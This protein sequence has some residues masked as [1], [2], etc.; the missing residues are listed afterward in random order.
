LNT[1]DA[2]IGN[3]ISN[4]TIQALPMEGR[5]VPDLLSL[6]PGVLYL[7]RQT[8][9]QQ[10]QDSRSGVVAGAR[11]DQSNITLDGVDNN[12]QTKGYAFQGV[13][14]STLDSVEEFRVTTTNSNA[15]A[16][17]S[18]GAQVVMVTKS[19]TNQFHGSL[20][21]YN[22]DTIFAANDWFNKQ[23][24]LSSG[25]PN[26]PGKLIRNTYGGTFGGP[27]KK[28]KLFFFFNYEGQR[29]AENA[30]QVWTV[31]TAAFRAGNISYPSNGQTISLTPA[32]IQQM[33]PNCKS[34]GTCAV[35]G[36]NPAVLAI[37]NQMP[38]PNGNVAGDGY[39]T[40]SF[41]WSA[42][43]PTHL[44]TT[45]AK[46]D[47]NLTNNNRLFIRGNLQDDRTAGPPVFPGTPPRYTLSTNNKGLAAGDSWTITPNLF[48]S[49]RYGY[50][51]QG[52]GNVGAGGNRS[53]VSITAISN[54]VA[55]DR[56]TLLN[57]P[58]HNLTDDVTWIKGRH[59]FQFGAN[60]RLLHNNSISDSTS[61][62]H[63]S[64]TVGL[65]KYVKVANESAALGSPYSLDP[66]GFGFPAVDGGFNFSYDTDVLSLTGI[67]TLATLQ[68]NYQVSKDGTTGTQLPV[69]TMIP[70]DFKANEFEWYVQDAWRV[71]PNLT[72][73]FGVR[74]S[75]LQTPYEVNGQQLQPDISMDQWFKSRQAGM[76]QGESIQ[77]FF[78]FSPSGQ[79]RGL[80]PYWPMNPLNFAPR[81]SVAYSPNIWHKIFGGPGKSSIRA[82]FG[83]FYDH[84]GQGIV[85]SFSQQGS[86]G[87]TTL[88]SSAQNI[89]TTDTAPRLTGLNDIPPL[90]GAP[91][92]SVK[93]PLTPPTDPFNSGTFGTGFAIAYG[94]NDHLKTPHAYAVDFSIQR[95]LPGGFSLEVAYVGRFGRNLLQEQDFAQPLDLV[96][97]KSGMDYY[98]ANGLLSAAVDQGKTTVAPIPYWENMFPAAAG[99]GQSATQNIYEGLWQS[100]RGNEI[101]GI[102]TL[103]LLCS[104]L[105]NP[106]NQNVLSANPCGGQFGRYFDPQFSSLFA[107]FTD[108]VANYNAAQL[109]LRHAMSRG[110]Q[111]DFSYTYG[112]SFDYGSDTERLYT[113]PSNFSVNP[114]SPILDAWHP[115]KNYGPSDFDTRHVIT[116]NGL[117]ELP[118]GLG[119]R[120]ANEAHG[121]VNALIGGWQF[122]GLGRWTSGLPFSVT[123]PLWSTNWDY[124]S[125]MIPTAPIPTKFNTNNGTPQVFPDPT[126]LNSG[127]STGNPWRFPYGGEVG[128]RNNF[129]GDGFFGID[130]GL[131]KSWKIR[132]G[133]SLKFA[134][135]VFNVTN[136]VR[137]DVNHNPPSNFQN[138]AESGSLGVYQAT[139][140]TPR[141]QQFSLR[142]VF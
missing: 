14:R 114:V 115:G 8:T 105:V 59:T 28:D 101:G 84:Y 6:Q 71:K 10:D 137:F 13:L 74:H 140:G 78:A 45:I 126:A 53:Y 68:S 130:A 11:S 82:G 94:L 22:R 15:D 75:L 17:R 81:V 128:P 19:G 77:P 95:E 103:D 58:L 44:N 62:A 80:K 124:N 70:R 90:V 88:L 139:L 104:P 98:T 118:F 65:I 132:E 46:I 34:Q 72:L 56:T 89:L 3:A 61:F 112:T 107:W 42:P 92:A 20:Y 79:A 18:S 43:N 91:P 47:Y 51:R 122:S 49:L 135:E 121:L 64:T 127:A 141:I 2:T 39:N 97:P 48:N 27:I 40:G 96:D 54:P 106:K 23:G 93:Y 67:T 57:V 119:K 9:A 41:S 83:M 24:E 129:R 66:A 120:F 113:N 29:T 31:P 35:N 30:Q 111:L 60:Y 100:E 142:Y 7:G 131:A 12:D 86:F 37:F 87:L 123:E 25:L 133:Q 73:T 4:A 138:G 38:L 85:N 52:F 69:G 21:E 134:W 16:G 102:Y 32:Q 33:D 136:S 109:M 116:V 55:E 63:A 110:F 26:K 1:T 117:Y 99:A 50:I 125:Y 108:G 36:P 76:L 5:N